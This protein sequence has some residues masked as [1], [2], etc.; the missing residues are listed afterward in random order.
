V[1]LCIFLVVFYRRANGALVG[2]NQ[3][4]VDEELIIWKTYVRFLQ[5]ESH[6][7][8]RRYFNGT[9]SICRIPSDGS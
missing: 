3:G 7:P 1:L 6:L 5:D 9:C 4:R 2:T 8:L